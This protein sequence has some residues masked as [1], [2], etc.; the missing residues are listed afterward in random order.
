MPELPEVENIVRHL[1]N[2]I[3]GATFRKVCLSNK[4]LRLHYP[5]DFPDNIINY[6]VVKVWRRSKY[7][8]ILLNFSTDLIK[9]KD[10]A[11]A[12][13]VVLVVHLGM[14]GKLLL[15]TKSN[16]EL[17]N[18]H[19]T[20][21]KVT[22][23]LP[24]SNQELTLIYHDPRR[25]GLVTTIPIKTHY[26]DHASFLKHLYSHPIF[27]SLGIEPL[28]ADFK[29]NFFSEKINALNKT[30][31]KRNI[32]SILMDNSILV[33]V[34]NIY[35]NESLFHAQINPN[36]LAISLS[37]KDCNNLVLAIKH[38]LESAILAGGSTLKDYKKADGNS[39]SFQNN[40]QVYNRESKSCYRVSCN[41]VIQKVVLNGRSTFYCNNC[42][43]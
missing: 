36:R 2:N 15:I 24:N 8:L 34:G 16:L 19:N 11:S 22:Y 38:I 25:F 29:S 4:S 37:D 13:S 10:C 21:V 33:G 40:F 41:G 26:Y 20:H 17:L 12:S 6:Q 23:T 31:S 3:I 39:G 28:T 27:F 1:H 14:S 9:N 32:K 7:I 43:L 30:N 18:N 5:N 35:A 42:Q